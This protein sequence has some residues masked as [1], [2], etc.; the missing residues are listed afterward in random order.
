MV[1]PDRLRGQIR[2]IAAD[3]RHRTRAV[4]YEA[5]LASH[6]QLH[7]GR[8]YIIERE[9]VVEQPNERSQRAGGVVVLRLAEQQGG[10]ALEVAQRGATMRP[11]DETASTTSG[12]GLFHDEFG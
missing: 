11:A 5:V 4:H 12:S 1:R 3:P 6:G 10:A 7:L 2:G 8:P 9:R